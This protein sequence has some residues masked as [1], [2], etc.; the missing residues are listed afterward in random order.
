MPILWGSIREEVCYIL[1]S[2]RLLV[3]K[4]SWG[5]VISFRDMSTNA[6]PTRSNRPMQAAADGKALLLRRGPRRPSKHVISVSSR[7]C[8]AMGA[9]PVVRPFPPNISFLG[10][11][12]VLQQNVC[13]ENVGAL[14]S[15]FTDKR[16][17]WA[18]ATMLGR[19][20]PLPP[21]QCRQA[22]P[23]LLARARH[24]VCLFTSTRKMT[25]YSA[26]LPP[27]SRQWQIR[28]TIPIPLPSLH[29]ILKAAIL[30]PFLQIIRP[31]IGH[32]K[33]SSL[34][35][36]DLVLERA[37]PLRTTQDKEQIRLGSLAGKRKN[38][39]PLTLSSKAPGCMNLY[40]DGVLHLLYTV[41]TLLALDICSAK[42]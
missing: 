23:L 18:P 6:T 25:S 11:I 5:S 15:S 31:S 17:L 12:V 13:P 14:M 29:C 26:P 40:L 22:P 4:F 20:D 42:P 21:A 38:R 2:S 10:I 9:I 36:G 7:A 8:H 3:A 27:P 39:R 41:I 32:N 30:I 34:A 37:L 24:R 19:R 28:S 33:L 16:R 1:G 35:R